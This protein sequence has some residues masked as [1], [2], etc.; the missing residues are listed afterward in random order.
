MTDLEK[1]AHAWVQDRNPN[2]D[3]AEHWYNKHK[4]TGG[5]LNSLAPRREFHITL[6][7]YVS[8]GAW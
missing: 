6:E 1:A 2:C 7:G 3:T 8:A 4:M 5:R